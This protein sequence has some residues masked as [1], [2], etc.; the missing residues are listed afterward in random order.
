MM[1]NF[2]CSTT[3]GKN[4]VLWER[5]NSP[6][7]QWKVIE[8][9]DYCYKLQ[10]MKDTARVLNRHVE[11]G[12]DNNNADAVTMNSNANA[13]QEILIGSSLGN[14]VYISMLV[15]DDP[16]VSTLYLTAVNNERG[17]GTDKT[18][19]SDGNVYWADDD[20]LGDKQVW[21]ISPSID[22]V[23]IPSSKYEYIC[24]QTYNWVNGAYNITTA[25]FQDYGCAAV[26]ATM[27]MQ[28][29]A[30]NPSITPEDLFEWGVIT[31]SNGYPYALWN[32][33]GAPVNYTFYKIAD[34]WS[35]AKNHIY[36][37][38]SLGKPVIIHLHEYEGTSRDGHFVV[39][40][41]MKANTTVSNM[42]YDDIYV[43]DPWTPNNETLS[44]TMNT[45]PLW[46]N[47]DN[48]RVAV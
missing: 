36:N 27:F 8:T 43:L 48:I 45:N 33:S 4:V 37:Q 29:M 39:G 19:D 47:F 23:I 5:D 38:L 46:A 31:S 3:K 34:N 41:G 40:I 35:S 17:N 26:T 13:T 42:T 30:N 11:S 6:E 28:I 7:Q 44:D 25:R 2:Y 18:P 9:S 12:A 10:T 15:F 14:T 32:T 24:Q 20:T 22:E 1:L 16:N 21:N